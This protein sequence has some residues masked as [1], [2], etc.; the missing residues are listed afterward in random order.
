MADGDNFFGS[1]DKLSQKK[2]LLR[3]VVDFVFGY[4]FFISYAWDDGANYASKLY[5]ELEADGFEVFLDRS[6]YAMGDDWETI[7]AWTL[8]RT[9]QLILVGSPEAIRS[10][11]VIREAE[12]FSATGRRIIPIDF[13]GS[14]EWRH[15]EPGLAPYLPKRDSKD[16]GSCVRLGARSV[17]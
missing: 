5:S 12:I 13:D 16:K 15:P 6:H 9:G 1:N 3:R 17:E 14:L 4:D 11:A 8:R 2:R 7:G 10:K